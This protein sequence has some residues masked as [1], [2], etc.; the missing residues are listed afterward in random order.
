MTATA[1]IPAFLHP[2]VHSPWFD[3]VK[4]APWEPGVY[5]VNGPFVG[6]PLF[7]YWDG[8]A[9]NYVA[10]KDPGYAFEQRVSRGGGCLV[11]RWR[12]IVPN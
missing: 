10:C 11:S 7:S 9:F 8:S 12:G 4:Q 5:E 1:F 2:P 3:L 6:E